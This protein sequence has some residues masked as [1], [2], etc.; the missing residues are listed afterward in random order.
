MRYVFALAGLA[1][2]AVAAPLEMTKYMAYYEPYAK[3]DPYTAAVEAEAAK[4]GKTY[5]FSSCL[6][7]LLTTHQHRPT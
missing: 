1:T 2:M 3:Y 5:I 6:S 4:M 7:T